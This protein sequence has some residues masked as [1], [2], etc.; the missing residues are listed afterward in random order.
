M[1]INNIARHH[2]NRISGHNSLAASCLARL[3]IDRE[4]EVAPGFRG[5]TC[6]SKKYNR[7]IYRDKNG[8]IT[9]RKDIADQYG[10][11]CRLILDIFTRNDGDYVKAHKELGA[12]L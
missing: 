11:S 4:L 1:S 2:A 9:K 3:E 7:T 10:L 12:R 8:N 6:R 5:E